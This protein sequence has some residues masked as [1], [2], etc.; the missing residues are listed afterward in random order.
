MR[1][2]LRIGLMPRTLTRPKPLLSETT[3]GVVRARLDQRRLFTGTSRRARE[4][5]LAE[6][7]GESKLRTGTSAVTS[8]TEADW[9]GARCGVREVTCPTWTTTLLTR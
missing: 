8:T 7:S 4:L 6:K 9:P 5:R 1:T 3:P 2:L